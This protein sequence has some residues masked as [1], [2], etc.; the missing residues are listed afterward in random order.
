MKKGTITV[1]EWFFD[2]T[3]EEAKNYSIL[4]V[5]E[6]INKDSHSELD[7]TKLRVDEVINETEKAYKVLLDAETFG[8]KYKGW[9]T[10]I[11]KSVILKGQ[12][13]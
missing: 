7:H 11:S 3:N 2:K 1:K 6:Y 8:G 10:W 13:D 5:G 9:K 4:L 12:E